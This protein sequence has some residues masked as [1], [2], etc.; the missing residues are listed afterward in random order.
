MYPLVHIGN[1]HGLKVIHVFL[2]FAKVAIS[3]MKDEEKEP[4]HPAKQPTD[5][6][7]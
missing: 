4:D 6:L 3:W 5:Q 1:A 2:A 7:E